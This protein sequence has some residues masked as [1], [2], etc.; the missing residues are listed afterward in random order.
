MSLSA[1]VLERPG[2]W[3]MTGLLSVA[4][5]AFLPAVALL[6]AAMQSV[7]SDLFTRL[8]GFFPLL[9]KSILICL[10]GA[11]L[12]LAL[13]LLAGIFYTLY[14]YPAR[15]LFMFLFF[16]PV[17]VPPLLWAVSMNSLASFPGFTSFLY[18]GRT[19]FILITAMVTFPL[20]AA[21]TIAACSGL[22]ASQCDAVRM[23]QGDSGLIRLIAR[24]AMPPAAVA[25][26]L[27]AFLMLSSPGPAMGLGIKTAVSEILVSFSA[28]YDMRLAALQCL[29]LSGSTLFLA[30]LALTAAGRRSMELLAT[31]SR[32]VQASYHRSM[33][34][35]AILF[36]SACSLLLV[37]LPLAGL[38]FPALSRPDMQAIST[39]L[40]RTWGYTMFYAAGSATT[41]TILGFMTGFFMGRRPDT[42]LAGMVC[43]L[44]I[45]SL[46]AAL[47]A[48]GF[49]YAGTRT[50]AWADFIFRGPMAVC[51]AQGIHLFPVP[52]VLA[53]RF[54]S[55]MPQSWSF[56]AEIHGISLGKFLI[57]VLAPLASVFIM[58]GFLL[59]LLLSAADTGT[60]LLIHPPG[61]Q[62][63]PLAIFTIMA[64]A[65][66]SLVAQLC[67]LYL[68]SASALFF[69]TYKLWMNRRT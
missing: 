3:R 22:S 28:L 60:V 17:M 43:L 6:H 1:L 62:N 63:L 18:S 31:S 37:L 68:V 29:M 4:C 58:T 66:E 67:L 10:S 65:P 51:L 27:G 15:K 38:L 55:Q 36:N 9:V 41:A 21:S 16:L 46:P 34:A 53:A 30:I 61:A 52:A 35:A 48:L 32:P 26:C 12:A 50:P 56:A 33:S 69:L 59:A 11:A 57:R 23:A 13:G 20:V 49:V 2:R 45:F 14:E 39:T 5:I 47:T 64:N 54:F 7:S 8:Q 44:L 25:A 24:F 19:A 42:R 40:S